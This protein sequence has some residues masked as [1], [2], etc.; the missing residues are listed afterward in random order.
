VCEVLCRSEIKKVLMIGEHD[1]RVGIS[2]KV[3]PPCFQDMDDG[4]KFMIVDLVVS[5]S[6]VK[7]LQKVSARMVCSI[8]VSLE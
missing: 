7:G 4:E 6:G 5:F 2:F 3:M 8:L 1:D